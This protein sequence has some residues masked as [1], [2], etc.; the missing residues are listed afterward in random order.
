MALRRPLKH[1]EWMNSVGDHSCCTWHTKMEDAYAAGQMA[2]QTKSAW[3]KMPYCL[4]LSL[5]QR[6]QVRESSVPSSASGLAEIM[7]DVGAVAPLVGEVQCR[8]LF[9]YECDSCLTISLI[10]NSQHCSEPGYSSSISRLLRPQ[11]RFQ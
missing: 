1:L 4:M 5:V 11:F 7:T 3:A 6:Q 8:R 10:S 9:G 2:Q